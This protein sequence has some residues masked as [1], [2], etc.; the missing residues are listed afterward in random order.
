MREVIWCSSSRISL[1][2]GKR[3][4]G[5]SE[6]R[7]RKVSGER[8]VRDEGG[9][10]EGERGEGERG[11]KRRREGGVSEGRERYQGRGM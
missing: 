5:R 3:E 9:R 1:G 11:R 4:R 7:E 8:N 10:G 6:R 2:G